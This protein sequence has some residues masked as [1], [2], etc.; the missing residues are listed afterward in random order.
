MNSK[1]ADK[2]YDQIKAQVRIANGLYPDY[3]EQFKS[4][5]QIPRFKSTKEAIKFSLKF[6]KQLLEAAETTKKELRDKER[7]VTSQTITI[8]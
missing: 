2:A 7:V 3:K 1:Y 5:D 4:E 8:N 6:N